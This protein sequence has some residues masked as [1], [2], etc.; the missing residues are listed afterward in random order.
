MGRIGTRLKQTARIPRSGQTP[1]GCSLLGGA[2]PIGSASDTFWMPVDRLG[3]TR[4][5]AAEVSVHARENR[6]TRIARG[7]P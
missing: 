4:S 5:T 7:S 1:T 3:F 6:R 2:A